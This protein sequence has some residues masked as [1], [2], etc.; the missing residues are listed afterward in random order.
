MN[1]QKFHCRK[2]NVIP[3]IL[4]RTFRRYATVRAAETMRGARGKNFEPSLM[5]SRVKRS[6]HFTTDF[7]VHPVFK[8]RSLYNLYTCF[9]P[10]FWGPFIGW[11]PGK[12]APP[13]PPSRRAW[14]RYAKV[15]HISY[16]SVL[17]HIFARTGSTVYL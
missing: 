2:S 11:G 9:T 13:C 10:S 6:C 12:I 7:K 5:T 17:E 14:L 16:K 1:F 3:N 15:R 4:F 8:H